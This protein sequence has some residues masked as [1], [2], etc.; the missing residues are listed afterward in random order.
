MKFKDAYQRFTRNSISIIEDSKVLNIKSLLE[1]MVNEYLTIEIDKIDKNNPDRDML[2]FEYGNYDWT[3]EGEKFNLSLKRQIFVKNSDECGFYGIRIYYN[4]KK[5]GQIED[6]SKWC[7][8]SN[9]ITEWKSII[10]N[11][12]GIKKVENLEF[13]KMEFELEKPH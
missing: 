7:M 8:N 3:G 13:L 1:L 5:I 11:T 12:D 9:S 2:L 10:E 4:T 6:F